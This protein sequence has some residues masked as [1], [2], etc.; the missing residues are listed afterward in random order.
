VNI[1]PLCRNESWSARLARE[2]MPDEPAREHPGGR[3]LPL[4]E[5]Y[6]AVPTSYQHD[7]LSAA[8][9]RFPFASW[10]R[11][12]Y[13]R[14]ALGRFQGNAARVTPVRRLRMVV[15]VL[16]NGGTCRQAAHR[17][18]VSLSTVVELKRAVMA[19]KDPDDGGE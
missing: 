15:K 3:M 1:S 9:W 17:A 14:D 6:A 16:A 11:Q 18:H 2:G 12:T 4:R 5:E 7:H 8:R 10:R 19:W 13:G